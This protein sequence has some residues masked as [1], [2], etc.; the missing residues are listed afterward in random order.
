MRKASAK[1]RTDFAKR[2]VTPALI[3]VVPDMRDR[4]L[5]PEQAEAGGPRKR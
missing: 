1:K 2:L 3:E 4:G 5:Q